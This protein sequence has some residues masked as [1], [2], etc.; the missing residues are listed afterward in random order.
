[1][2]RNLT[3]HVYTELL[4]QPLM[5]SFIGSME[6]TDEQ[7]VPAPPDFSVSPSPSV[8]LDRVRKALN[9]EPPK[10]V[11]VIIIYLLCSY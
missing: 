6:A 2:S 4:P 8:L 11:S 5:N 10:P 7:M 3:T 1:M 9:T